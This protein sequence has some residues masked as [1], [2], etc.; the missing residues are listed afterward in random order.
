MENTSI[1]PRLA[2]ALP[3]APTVN[4][5]AMAQVTS[6]MEELLRSF[7]GQKI[8]ECPASGWKQFRA[9]PAASQHTAIAAIRGQ[10]DFIRG[11]VSDG[12]QVKNEVEML[13]YAMRTL[14]LRAEGDIFAEIED[15]D[16]IEVVDEDFFQVY[17]SYSCFS[18]CNYSLTQLTA[19]PWFELYERSA[20][21]TKR[22]IQITQDILRGAVTYQSLAGFP[23]YQIRELLTDQLTTFTIRE[24][25]AAKLTSSLTGAPYLLSVKK[26]RESEVQPQL[27]PARARDNLRFI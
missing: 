15:G 2:P 21:V 23:E 22:L 10:I 12:L 3:L 9:L 27:D 4:E 6:V 5:I 20:L 25:F 16:V 8:V 19:Y 26:I 18:L 11:A 7:A 24:K 14:S 13:R 1:L 17:R